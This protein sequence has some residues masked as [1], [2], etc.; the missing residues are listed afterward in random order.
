MAERERITGKLVVFVVVDEPGGLFTKSARI[1]FDPSI[2]IDGI[3]G[4]LDDDGVFVVTNA[5]VVEA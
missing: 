3:E 4:Y 5:K 1:E 2:P